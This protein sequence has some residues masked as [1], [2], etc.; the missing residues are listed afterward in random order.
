MIAD[1]Q[2]QT[3]MIGPMWCAT[4]IIVEQD[5]DSRGRCNSTLALECKLRWNK[6]TGYGTIRPLEQQWPEL[7]FVMHYIISSGTSSKTQHLFIHTLQ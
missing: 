4:V 1:W 2:I 7:R 5:L 3:H 6:V